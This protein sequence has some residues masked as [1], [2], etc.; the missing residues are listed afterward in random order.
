MGLLAINVIGFI[1][2][3]GGG[4]EDPNKF[5]GDALFS[6]TR[7]TVAPFLIILGYLVIMYSIMR[8]PKSSSEEDK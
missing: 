4:T 6:S 3:L 1:L 2:M 7:I 8:K 5:D